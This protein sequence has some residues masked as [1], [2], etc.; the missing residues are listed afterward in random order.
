M[1]A[2]AV[3]AFALLAAALAVVLWPL[4]RRSAAPALAREQSNLDIHR[5]QFAELARDVE[6]GALGAQ[7]YEQARDELHRRV[8]EEAAGPAPAR[9]AAAG[10][11]L[12]PILIAFFVPLT[13]IV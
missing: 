5:D 7:G 11:K 9:Q 1:I 6:A 13:A 3:V 2:F 4:L 8:L 12:A 10:G